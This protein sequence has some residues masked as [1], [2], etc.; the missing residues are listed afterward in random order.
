LRAAGFPIAHLLGLAAPAYAETADRLILTESAMRQAQTQAL[1]VLHAAL[2]RAGTDNNLRRQL[3]KAIRQLKKHDLPESLSVAEGAVAVDAFRAACAC[4]DATVEHLHQT[5]QTAMVQIAQALHNIARDD[6]FREAVIWQNRDALHNGIDSVLRKH[7]GTATSKNRRN[8]M[9]VASYLQRYCAK[10]DTIGFFGPVGWAQF[11]SHGPALQIR[12]GPSLIATRNVYFESWCIDALADM[13]SKNDQLLPWI[14]PRRLPHVRLDGTTLHLPLAPPIK[15]TPAQAA[16]LR[17]CDGQ[18]SARELAIGLSRDPSCGVRSEAEVYAL[19]KAMRATRRIAWSLEIPIEGAYPEKYLRQ[20][21]ERIQDQQ[22]RASALEALA[23][24]EAARDGLVQM[25]TKGN[26]A[27]LDRAMADMEATFIRLTNVEPTRRAGLS[28]AARTLVYED[29]RRDVEI[30]LGPQILDTLGPPLTLL[31][32]SAR[33]LTFQVAASYRGRLREIYDTLARKTRST[34]LDFADFWLMAQGLVTGEHKEPIQM[35]RKQFQER[36]ATILTPALNERRLAYRSADLL[37]HVR[38]TFAVP[39]PGWRAA[40]YHSPDIM[41]TAASAEAI[42]QGDYQFVMGELHPGMNALSAQTFVLHHPEP[43]ALFRAIEH[44][45]Q[46]PRVIPVMPKQWP[47]PTSRTLTMLMSP[48]DFRLLYAPDSCGFTPSQALASS[49]LVVET[50]GAGLTVRTRDRQLSFDV[51]E[52]F[53]DFLTHHAIQCFKLL[54]PDSHTPRIT[55]DRLVICRE[56]WRFA[57]ADLAFLV[58]E[59]GPNRFV[60]T[61]RWAH[62]HG[63]PRFVFLKIPVEQKPCYIDFDSP[64]FVDIFT[65]MV[66]RTL[67]SSTEDRSILVTEM[68]PVPDQAWLTDA[69]GQHYTSELRIVAVDLERTIALGA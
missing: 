45:L 4:V 30:D 67:E 16:V 61:R 6:R 34:A 19:L 12:P 41:I 50:S 26:A 1:N 5:S 68:L 3:S 15:I 24:L 56:S 47:A 58:T 57:A 27:Q 18:R 39:H 44:D 22:L 10:N 31:L 55:I 53:A 64:I 9:L 63:M 20:L 62:D 11:V 59:A 2:R 13:L 40:C 51:C 65:R 29:C 8:K 32:T 69:Q 38:A 17:A 33:W 48:K 36:W 14:A 23:E 35:L 37:S 43:Q 60:A 25:S 46:E 66:C 21:L 49:A 54:R 52:V 7:P 42:R 28:Y